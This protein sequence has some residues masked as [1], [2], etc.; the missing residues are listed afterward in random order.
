MVEKMIRRIVFSVL[1]EIEN[2]PKP[3]GLALF[4]SYTS[5]MGHGTS[6]SHPS[7]PYIGGPGFNACDYHEFTEKDITEN[8][9]GKIKIKGVWFDTNEV[10]FYGDPRLVSF[11]R[12]IEKKY[13]ISPWTKIHTLYDH[14]LSVSSG[15]FGSQNH[16]HDK[17]LR[18]QIDNE[19]KGQS[20]G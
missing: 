20:N 15:I 12:E 18:E 7:S 1:R 17:E 19:M 14:G 8:I 9:N 5:C 13:Q 10:F 2:S 16:F 3:I 11:K 6:F 4:R